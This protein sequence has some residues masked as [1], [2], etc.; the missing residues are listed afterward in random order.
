MQH[1]EHNLSQPR[2]VL[3]KGSVRQETETAEVEVPL[4]DDY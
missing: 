3:T 1:S 2:R 4:G